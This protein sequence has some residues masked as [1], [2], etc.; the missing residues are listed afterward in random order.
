[1]ASTRIVGKCSRCCKL[2]YVSATIEIGAFRY[3]LK[4]GSINNYGAWTYSYYVEVLDPIIETVVVVRQ[5]GRE[6]TFTFDQTAV[7]YVIAYA[8]INLKLNQQ[9]PNSVYS[10]ALNR[11][12]YIPFAPEGSPGIVQVDHADVR[13]V[14]N[15]TGAYAMSFDLTGV[16]QN[17]IVYERSFAGVTLPISPGSI[18]NYIR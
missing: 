3:T 6:E 18:S 9:N 10:Q 12:L 11:A 8:S 2:P 17:G 4:R 5:D 13:L 16:D 7:A 15:A 1:M 14:Y